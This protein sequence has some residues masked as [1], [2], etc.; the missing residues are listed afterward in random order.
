MAFLM[1]RSGRFL[2]EKMPKREGNNYITGVVLD[3]VIFMWFL[4]NKLVQSNF[5]F[6]TWC[7]FIEVWLISL[8]SSK[9][10]QEIIIANIITLAPRKGHVFNFLVQRIYVTR[11][12]SQSPPLLNWVFP[13]VNVKQCQYNLQLLMLCR[14]DTCKVWNGYQK[15]W[16]SLDKYIILLVICV[17]WEKWTLKMVSWCLCACFHPIQFYTYNFI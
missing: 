17:G 8:H 10:H 1:D 9:K 6:S 5:I 15:W 7:T 11:N 14:S 4:K 2:R 13:H 12:S 3:K 16:G